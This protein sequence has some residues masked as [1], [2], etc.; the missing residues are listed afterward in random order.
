MS[1][2]Q[3]CKFTGGALTPSIIAQRLVVLQAYNLKHDINAGVWQN[4]E[5]ILRHGCVGYYE[6]KPDEAVMEWTAQ[7]D[8]FYQMY[9]LEPTPIELAIDDPLSGNRC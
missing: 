8:R 3:I 9:E 2:L 1:E 4:I 5:M 6:M 7:Q